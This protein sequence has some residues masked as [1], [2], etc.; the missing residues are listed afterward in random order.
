MRALAGVNVTIHRGEFIALVGANGSGKSTLAR[1]CNGLLLPTE[2]TVRVAGRLTTE[3]GALAEIRR[4]VG[5]VW[6]DP[7]SQ[8]VGAT[9]EEDVAFGP[10][11]LGLAPAE[12][13][14]RVDQALRLVGLEGLRGRPVNSLSGGQKQLLAIAGV[15]A[16]APDVLILDEATAMLHPAGREQV[17]GL[18]QRLALGQTMAVVVVTHHMDEAMAASRVIAMDTGRVVFDGPPTRL[19][20]AGHLLDRIG[21]AEP[22]LVNIARGLREAGVDV[23][24]IWRRVEDL[25]EHLC[26]LL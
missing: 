22:P 15:L 8:L 26:R 4:Q 9:L 14:V 25:A 13:D 2:G 10:A 6:Q 12:I 24:L 23:P 3:A 17:L 20:A 7:D 18:A 19:L 1:L 16:M 21:L 11:N 5:V